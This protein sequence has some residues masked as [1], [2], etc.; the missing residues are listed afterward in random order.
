MQPLPRHIDILEESVDEIVLEN[1]AVEDIDDDLHRVIAADAVVERD[2]EDLEIIPLL[3]GNAVGA[4]I[5]RPVLLLH[6]RDML[7]ALDIRFFNLNH[8]PALGA[9]GSFQRQQFHDILRK[10]VRIGG[11][12]FIFDSSRPAVNVEADGIPVAVEDQHA[13]MRVLG[14]IS[15]I[16]ENAVAPVFGVEQMLVPQNA[17]ETRLAEFGGAIAFAMPI[18]RGDEQELLLRYELP[19]PWGE[20][21]EDLPA[22]KGLSAISAA[23]FHLQHM[24][25]VGARQ[26]ARIFQ[27]SRTGANS[28]RRMGGGR[29]SRIAPRCVDGLRGRGLGS[30]GSFPRAAHETKFLP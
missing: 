14:K 28:F 10:L 27:L 7:G 24:L 2:V 15:E 29:K 13:D 1:L 16:G 12:F 6:K 26:Q 3:G 11:Q 19:H 9:F 21:V 20:E 30:N 5:D 25:A 8:H 18:S 22:V 4:P 23:V 17:N